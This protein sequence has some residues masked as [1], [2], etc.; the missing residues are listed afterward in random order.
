MIIMKDI[1]G[2]GEDV[3]NA[4][5][6]IRIDEQSGG[7]RE[8]RHP[9][10]PHAMNWC[11][12]TA[13]WGRVRCGLIT[14]YERVH[15]N[16]ALVRRDRELRFLPPVQVE[17]TEDGAVVQYA[18]ANIRVTAHRF[19]QGDRYVERYVVKNLREIDL[20]LE[21]G[22]VGIMVPFN[23][24]YTNALDCRTNRCHTHI[25]CGENCTYINALKMGESDI[26]LGLMLTKGSIRSYS[27]YDTYTNHRG[28][29]MLN[30]PHLELLAGEEYT[31]EWELFWHGGKEDFHRKAKAYDTFVDIRAPHYTVFED[32]S[33]EF[34]VD[35]TKPVAVF[36][37]GQ[38]IKVCDGAVCHRP[39]RLGEHRFDITVG[40][41]HTHA[42]FFVSEP[43]DTV[44]EKRVRFIVNN[45]QY[46]RADSALDGAFLIYD[47]KEKSLVF[48]AV[49]RDHNAC[50]E[51]LGMGL[52]LVKYLQKQY[53]EQI[54]QSLNRYMTFV[55]REMVDVEKG[56]VY[57]GIN[58]NAKFKRLYNAPWVTTLFV[59][60]Y[61]LTGDTNYLDYTYTLLD[62]Y[63]QNGGYAF[64]PNGLSMR[65]TVEAF[66]R[67]G[68]HD[69]G[70][71]ILAMFRKH[72]DNIVENGG[73]YPKHEVAF[74]QTIVSP[75]ATFTAEMAYLTDDAV[76]REEARKHVSIL[77]RFNGEQPSC[78][79]N[80][81]PIRYWD[82]YW[83]GKARL[84]G[85]TFPHYWSCLSGRSMLAYVRCSGDNTY[86]QA[87]ERTFRNCLCLFNDKGEGSC[88]YVY[89]F[90]LNGEQG[91]FYDDWANDQDYALYYYLDD[92][93]KK[94]ESV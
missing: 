28:R 59:E 75:A 77:A 81:I 20:F 82:D 57:D 24:I 43:L 9:R 60:Y 86:R 7:L 10:D 54:M 79:L 70:E 49:A 29:I 15:G 27:V 12:D 50:R 23:D 16:P 62:N 85:D 32:E 88:A 26:N 73:D 65:Q 35:T 51:R 80:E 5:F 4:C 67:A 76:Y 8:L 45:Q 6:D 83:F 3:T 91:A 66:R 13:D 47:V 64:Y 30:L 31:V 42:E 87:A 1:D 63:Y 74:E 71:A 56:E 89:P 72:T 21:H 69:K 93:I 14:N 84:F 53:D 18:D 58:R 36:C 33:I 34:A 41:V 22:D 94:E 78:H 46:T 39:T 90:T 61:Y 19:L 52:L 55:L 44:V 25:W 92:E 38:P 2:K 48:D 68:M 40:D 11:L 37:D 17:Q